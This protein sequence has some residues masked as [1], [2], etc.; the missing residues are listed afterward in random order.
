MLSPPICCSQDVV[1]LSIGYEHFP[2]AE[3]A[4][5]LSDAP[6]LEIETNS[7]SVSGAFP[8]SFKDGKIIVFNSINYKKTYFSYENLPITATEI[9][10]AQYIE[11]SAFMIDSLSA[12]WKLAAML[13]PMLA[14]DFESN[15]SRDDL[16]IGGILG[17][18]RTIKPSLEI[19]FGVAY[20]S[21]FGTP[22]PL[23]F[24]YLN[25]Q[26]KPGLTINGIIP[27]NLTTVK[28]IT[29]W[30]DIGGEFTVDGNRFHGSPA[31]FGISRPFMRYSEGTLSAL[32]RLHFTDWL[33]LNMKAGWGFYRNFE[34][35]SGKEKEQSFDLKRVPYLGGQVILGF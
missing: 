10:Q 23:P 5:P 28:K 35:Y 21:D 32:G 22:I 12:K 11:Y 25:W 18:I 3:L 1:G 19:G 27:S 13:M 17:L 30:F 26:P 15:L 6:G 14:S 7:L 31:K 20:L 24:I 33:H 29:N 16:I 4:Q 2:S 8:L 9:D 34:F